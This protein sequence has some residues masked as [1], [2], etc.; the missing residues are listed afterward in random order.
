MK[1]HSKGDLLPRQHEWCL[2]KGLCTGYRIARFEHPGWYDERGKNVSMICDKWIPLTEI[3][4]CA[5]NGLQDELRE[6]LDKRRKERGN[7]A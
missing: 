2:C 5:E 6:K 4:D 3:E 7:K 1:W